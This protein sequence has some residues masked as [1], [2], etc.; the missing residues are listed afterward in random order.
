VLDNP[1]R[2]TVPPR[3]RGQ[4]GSSRRATARHYL[5]RRLYL[6]AAGLC[7]HRRRTAFFPVLPRPASGTRHKSSWA[8][9]L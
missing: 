5:H 7:R 8:V 9:E 1:A 4:S 2:A 6:P 3:R